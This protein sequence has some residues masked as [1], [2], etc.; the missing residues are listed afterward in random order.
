[1]GPVSQDVA[2][3]V[4]GDIACPDLRQQVLPVCV[5]AVADACDRGCRKC[6]CR[7][8]IG[9]SGGHIA[10]VVI[11]VCRRDIRSLVIIC[12]ISPPSGTSAGIVLAQ[13]TADVPEETSDMKTEDGS[14]ELECRQH[15]GSHL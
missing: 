15:F 9:L 8:G 5:R 3:A 12:G 2:G 6:T 13:M 14:P 11:S 10:A 7:V 1:M 4:A